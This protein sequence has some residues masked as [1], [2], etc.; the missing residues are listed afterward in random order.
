[1]G[2]FGDFSWLK[3][4]EIEKHHWRSEIYSLFRNESWDN[5]Y[6]FGDMYWN[7]T[8]IRLILIIRIV[9]FETGKQIELK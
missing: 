6:S 8:G 2:K 1:M 5:S 9:I 7:D 3:I 4:N